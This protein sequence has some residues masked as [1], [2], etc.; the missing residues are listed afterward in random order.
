LSLSV[1]ISDVQC[2]HFVEMFLRIRYRIMTKSIN[3]LLLRQRQ[4][5]ERYAKIIQKLG[6]HKNYIKLKRQ[7]KM[8]KRNELDDETN[9]QMYNIQ[10]FGR[11]TTF[12]LWWV[13]WSGTHYRLSFVLC[14]S[15]LVTLSA[16]LRRYYSRDISACSRDVCMTLRYINF[17]FCSILFYILFAPAHCSTSWSERVK[18]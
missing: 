2:Q 16:R 3:H 7:Y 5:D 14:L 13:R 1:G 18:K 15:V 17:Q 4:H 11:N 12:S 6:L 9:I 10:Y 8:C